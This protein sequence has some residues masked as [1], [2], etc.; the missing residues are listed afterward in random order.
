MREI[1]PHSMTHLAGI[2][3]FMWSKA[4]SKFSL[5]QSG[6]KFPDILAN[7]PNLLN[8]INHSS[9]DKGFVP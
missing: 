5:S 7:P 3:K 9:D 4:P 8:L 2:D 6:N 1:S